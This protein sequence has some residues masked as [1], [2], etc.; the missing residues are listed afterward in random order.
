MLE[1]APLTVLTGAAGWFGR[2]FLDA[3]RSPTADHGPVGRDGRVRVLVERP[4]DVALVLDR[5]PS[6]EVHV[7]DVADPAALVRLFDGAA[8]ASVVHAAGVIHPVRVTDFD[9]VNAEGTRR[10]VEAAAR[11]GVRRLVHVSSN[12][13]IGVNAGRDDTFR[14]DEPFR[15]YLGYGTSKM[16]AELAVRAAQDEGRLETVVVRPPWFYGPWQPERQTRFFSLVAAGRFP[17]LGDGRQRRSMAYVDNL[18]QGVALAER[19]PDAPGRTFWVADAR[20]YEMG[21]ILATVRRVLAQEG[22]VTA[23]RQVRA[24]ALVGR[25]A[26]AADR[27]LQA[28]GRY[29]AEVHVLGEMDKTI[30]CDIRATRSVLG[31]DPRV[32]LEEGMRRS[33]RWCRDQG[34]EPAPRKGAR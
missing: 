32:A 18:V 22:Y 2:A 10:V 7:G 31:Y 3:V 23:A 28:R 30:A 5:L 4:A 11:A 26:E 17:L 15:P 13:P 1:P 27:R 20:A 34:I 9:R 14:A 33:V 16:A 12:S 8:G 19:H 21:E 29:V 24:P 25:L 6:A